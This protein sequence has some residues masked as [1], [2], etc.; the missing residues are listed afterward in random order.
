M[1]TPAWM[2]DR[3]Q[4][5]PRL[6]LL[7]ASAL[8]G[9]SAASFRPASSWV[10]QSEAE[11][12][13]AYASRAIDS[14]VMYWGGSGRRTL[15]IALEDGTQGWFVLDFRGTVEMAGGPEPKTRWV[16]HERDSITVERAE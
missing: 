10:G 3:L 5:R 9:C 12:R 11:V 14:G 8:L 4:R 16:H 6:A 2:A 13:G 1:A 7:L 15:Y